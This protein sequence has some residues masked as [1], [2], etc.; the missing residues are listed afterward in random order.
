MEKL[1]QFK[2][3]GAGFRYYLWLG[4][5][6]MIKSNLFFGVGVG[7]YQH[8]YPLFRDV[9]EIN[10]YGGETYI[11]NAEND[12]LQILAET[13]LIGLFLFL[14]ILI[15]V[16]REGFGKIKSS[17]IPI[18]FLI[19][20]AVLTGISSGL[21][22]SMFSFN[23]RSPVSSALFW[24][25]CGM[26]TSKGFNRIETIQSEP[27]R[28]SRR[29]RISTKMIVVG[30]S[31][32]IF[33]V[34]ATCQILLPLV[35]DF[36]YKK[37]KVEASHGDLEKAAASM[38]KSC[39]SYPYDFEALLYRG[40]ILQNMKRYKDSAE[41]IESSLRLHE[42]YPFSYNIQGVNYHYLKDIENAERSYKKVLQLD[43][44]HETARKNLAL[45]YKNTGRMK[46]AIN[47]YLLSEKYDPFD[48]E[49]KIDI[50]L[51]YYNIGN[52]AKAEEYF[53][54]ALSLRPFLM[55]CDGIMRI[56]R[57]K[58]Q[59]FETGEKIYFRVDARNRYNR[60]LRNWTK[61]GTMIVNDIDSGRIRIKN[62]PF[63]CR[64]NFNPETKELV[65]QISRVN[66]AYKYT[67]QIKSPKQLVDFE[68]PA[69][70]IYHAKAYNNLG[71][72]CAETN[73]IREARDCFEKAIEICPE[74]LPPYKNLIIH[75]LYQE[76]QYEKVRNIFTEYKKRSS[77]A[78]DMDYLIDEMEY[79]KTQQE[80]ID[81]NE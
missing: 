53:R 9:R 60:E 26:L 30:F 1:L 13:G 48:E 17:Q 34:I 49:I 66:D 40:L 70:A 23:L 10:L 28:D 51:I 46:E 63:G 73:K 50:G 69:N 42:Y 20:L 80:A 81:H 4:T 5:L 57:D 16:F 52:F 22:Q 2:E 12:F 58:Y 39:S 24:I 72:V 59:L 47:E 68:I 25:L 79:L 27:I 76:P 67:L 62:P 54:K 35:A 74:Y 78:A 41:M 29:T 18:S 64:L 7:N 14:V 11:Y 21:I 45:I 61:W 77:G 31:I 37:A 75:Y 19:N 6:K 33:L 43:P 56:S 8:N 55:D 71:I 38:K 44:T 3:G 65:L 36:Y 15:S 32:T